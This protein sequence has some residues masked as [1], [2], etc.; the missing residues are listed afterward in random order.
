MCLLPLVKHLNTQNPSYFKTDGCLHLA[1]ICTRK[2]P[3]LFAYHASVTE[4]VDEKIEDRVSV[5]LLTYYSKDFFHNY[6]KV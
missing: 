4:P 2:H 6:F 5:V 3:P 1:L